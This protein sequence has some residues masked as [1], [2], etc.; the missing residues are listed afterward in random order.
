L[1]QAILCQLSY[2][3]VVRLRQDRRTSVLAMAGTPAGDLAAELQRR[4][5]MF[6]AGDEKYSGEWL[7]KFRSTDGAWHVCIEAL[8]IGPQEDCDS[9]LLHGYCAQ[10]LAQLARAFTSRCP[11]DSRK[12]NRDMLE[13]LVALHAV[14][15]CKLIWKQL[16]LALTCA[17]LWLGTWSAATALNATNLPAAVRRELLTLPP[18][19]LFSERALP[20][21]DNRL[22]EAAAVALFDASATVF[23]YL[24]AGGAASEASAVEAGQTLEVLGSWLRSM[25]KSSEYVVGRDQGAPLRCLA[26]NGQP[27]LA[28]LGAAPAEACDVAQQL[29]SWHDCDADLV[30]MLQAVLECI[31]S[32]SFEGDRRDALL[33]LLQ[34][35]A[36]D[37]WPRAAL[38]SLP[39][40]ALDWQAIAQQALVAL[41]SALEAGDPDSGDAET[42]IAVWQTFAVTVRE[43]SSNGTAQ[44]SNSESLPQLFGLLGRELLELLKAPAFPDL[45]ALTTLNEA[46]KAAQSAVA[47][48]A[49][50]VG[51]SPGWLE[52]TW[53]PLHHVGQRLANGQ[54]GEPFADDFW[55]ELEVVLWFSYTIAASWP[56]HAGAVPVASA[57]PELSAIDGAPEPWRALL[58]A[59]ACSLASTGPSE[60]C[61]ALVE[62]MLRRPPGESGSPD[63]LELTELPYA[64]AVEIACRHLPAGGTAHVAA[65]ERLAALAFS[66]APASALHEDSSK[67]RGLLVRAMRHTLGGDAGLLCQGLGRTLPMLRKAAEAEA[68]TEKADQP[69]HAAQTLFSSLAAALPAVNQPVVEAVHPVVMLW[70]EYWVCIESALLRWPVS[71]TNDQPLAS[72]VEALKAAALSLPVLLPEALHLLTRSITHRDLPEL[73]LRALTEIV[74][75]VPCPPVDHARAADLLSTSV[76]AAGDALLE[77]KKDLLESPDL[78][79]ALFKLFSSGFAA[80]SCGGKLRTMLL[81]NHTL[82]G[83]SISLVAETLPDCISAAAAEDM[84][85]FTTLL[86]RGDDLR[87]AS[88]RETLATSLPQLCYALCRALASQEYLAQYEGLIDVAE[89]LLSAADAFPAEM[90][91]S[92]E[93]GSSR[94]Q[95]LPEWSRCRLSQHVAR[96]SEWPKKGEW[97]SHLQ[98]IVYEWQGELRCKFV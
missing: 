65:A 28:M 64:S 49:I 38:G 81:A 39:I 2:P 82:A 32:A 16:A 75:C 97:V 24:L 79:R 12:Q 13:M 88:C 59:S 35:L 18:E 44:L 71:S 37:R 30:P 29:A 93:S 69:W 21:G 77:R 36:A 34:A 58:W 26:A 55:S 96:R 43:C 89:V 51:E 67:S 86:M 23:P 78:L 33:P 72:A 19:L 52:A 57:V 15:P 1:A 91:V 87:T 66:E 85:H 92:L 56:E 20:L 31:F 6:Y 76:I 94:V 48:W 22:W 53:A 41:R 46:R 5:T 83:R 8:R 40:V 17:D 7:V 60:H 4:V 73:Q 63:L 9:E 80:S 84:L 70:K 54:N 68:A 45:E 90:P 10:T 95:E 61:P 14:H 74:L 50:L 3:S 98:Q 27:L 62:W 25:R 47:A 11:A 42:A